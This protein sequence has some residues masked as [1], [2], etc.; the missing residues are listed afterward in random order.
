[1]QTR[2]FAV[3]IVGAGPAGVTA[4]GVGDGS[5]NG[6]REV[7]SGRFVSSP[8]ERSRAYHIISRKISVVPPTP[9][10]AVPLMPPFV[11][12]HRAILPVG[13]MTSF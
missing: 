6:R 10:F 9:I 7:L 2:R 5:K 12:P 11:D 3:V 4:A 8:L 13:L 1:M